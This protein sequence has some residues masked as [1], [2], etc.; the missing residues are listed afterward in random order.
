M[1]KVI[2][3]IEKVPFVRQ[4]NT[5][6]NPDAPIPSIEG[7]QK[8]QVFGEGILRPVWIYFFPHQF[9]AKQKKYKERGQWLF[10]PLPTDE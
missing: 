7:K 5:H 1:A 8:Y 6:I 3:P 10:G 2:Q 9:A 4:I